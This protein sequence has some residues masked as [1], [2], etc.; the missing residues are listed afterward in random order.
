MAEKSNNENNES[1]FSAPFKFLI[2]SLTSVAVF[3]IIGSAAMGLNFIVHWA[4]KREVDIVI[5]YGMKL[6]EY[7]LFFVDLILFLRFIYRS[8]Q[9]MWSKL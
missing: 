6:T 4:E 9:R 8:A 7:V 1:Y 3:L 2:E 5:I